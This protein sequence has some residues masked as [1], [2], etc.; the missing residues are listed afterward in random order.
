MTEIEGEYKTKNSGEKDK[1]YL[2]K[3]TQS[4]CVIEYK[5]EIKCRIHTDQGAGQLRT[6]HA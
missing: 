6:A 5:G 3:C 4:V 1:D 2:I